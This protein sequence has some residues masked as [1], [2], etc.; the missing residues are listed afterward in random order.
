MKILIVDDSAVIRSI[1]KQ[2]LENDKSITI[3]GEASNGKKAVDMAEELNPDLIIMDLNMPV[4]NGIEATQQ[5]MKKS[6]TPILIFSGEVDAHSGFDA[7]QKGAVE[8]LKKPDFHDINE[9]EFVNSFIQRIKE[10]EKVHS[11]TTKKKYSAQK[12]CEDDN[13]SYKIC[14]IG[15]STG[16]PVA[17]KKILTDLPADFPLGIAIVQHLEKGF[18][19]GYTEWLN[20]QSKLT[21]RLAKINDMPK[22]GEVIVSPVDVHLVLNGNSFTYNDGPPVLNQK[23][24]VDILFKSAAKSYGNKVLAV[25]LT[26]MGKDGGEGCVAIKEKCGFT[27]V[28]DEETSTIFGMPQAAIELGGASVVLPLNEI[29]EFLVKRTEGSR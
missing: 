24:S 19:E 15:A 11:A 29:A 17:I 28:Q 21:V 10:L 13:A 18:E 7:I 9:P 23:P 5:I 6:P 2:I 16:G 26:G 3:V 12:A 1:L 20:D 14:L 22:P 25:L 4:L 8:I 27:V